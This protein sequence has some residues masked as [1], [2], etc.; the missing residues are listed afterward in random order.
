[1]TAPAHVARRVAL[2]CPPAEV[3]FKG[4]FRVRLLLDEDGRRR[5]VPT[6][7]AEALGLDPI[8][9]RKRAK[10]AFP[11]GAAITASPSAGGLQ[12]VL[13]LDLKYLPAL[14]AG[15]DV[16]RVRPEIRL[17]LEEIQ[18]ELHEALA[19]YVFDGAAVNPAFGAASLPPAPQDRCAQLLATL[20]V[21]ASEAVRAGDKPAA[22][23]AARAFTAAVAPRERRRG[24][25]PGQL[26]LDLKG[27][28]SK[29]AT[30]AEVRLMLLAFVRQANA[31]GREPT[32]AE[33]RRATRTG[34]DLFVRAM[35]DLMADRLLDRTGTA[36]SR[37]RAL[38]PATAAP[39]AP[40][41]SSPKPEPPAAPTPLEARKA[42][43]RA[44]ILAALDD[45]KWNR[46]QTAQT[47]RI[48]RRT[49][50]RRLKK[51]GIQ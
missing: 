24:P 43:E 10:R 32:I 48:P 19:A 27:R 22:R 28:P 3:E 42:E 47:L 5:V 11:K 9:F 46:A 30:V 25:A 13:T 23:A 45:L 14:L 33:T 35:Q 12:D 34:P 41:T 1:M 26:P 36:L 49:F 38:E 29:P 17:S 31:A 8:S 18:E 7:I 4:L 2:R 6:E 44:R 16:G 40:A 20:A 15:I 37:L 21:H 51:Y 50:Y 39:R